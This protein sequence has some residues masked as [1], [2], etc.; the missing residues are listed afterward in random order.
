MLA[1]GLVIEKMRK[2]ASSVIGR[3]VGHVGQAVDVPVD[4]LA[5]VQDGGDHV[6]EA[7][8]VD[9]AVGHGGD[10]GEPV[11]VELHDGP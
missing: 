10:V 3:C 2:M 6:G 8:V 7:P 1:I 5:V 4:L 9:V 11:R